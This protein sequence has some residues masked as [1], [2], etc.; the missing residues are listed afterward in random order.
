MKGVVKR[1][2]PTQVVWLYVVVASVLGGAIAAYFFVYV[3]GKRQYFRGEAGRHADAIAEHVREAVDTTATQ[4]GH[5]EGEIRDDSRKGVPF[6]PAEIGSKINLIPGLEHHPP[7]R[8][9]DGASE[10]AC[11][12]PNR[13]VLVQ[14]DWSYSR[15]RV[16]YTLCSEGGTTHPAEECP[17]GAFCA[18][19]SLQAL[20]G[21]LDP[22]NVF[23]DVALG[24]REGSRLLFQLREKPFRLYSPPRI[25]QDTGDAA[26]AEAVGH[27]TGDQASPTALRPA[28]V[29]IAGEGYEL[30]VGYVSLPY[31]GL[32][33]HSKKLI[34]TPTWAVYGWISSARMEA[35]SR[36]LQP[37]FFVALLAAFLFALALPP[38]LK[39]WVLSPGERLRAT[40]IAL[41]GIA[42]LVSAVLGTIAVLATLANQV[43]DSRL[44]QAMHNTAERLDRYV[45]DAEQESSERLSQFFDR[46]PGSEEQ[47]IRVEGGSWTRSTPVF[48]EIF[49]RTD[50]DGKQD[51]KWSIRDARTPKISV[52]TRDYFNHAKPEL[53]RS[54]NTGE[55]LLTAVRRADPD[56]DSKAIEAGTMRPSA[57]LYPVLPIGFGFAILDRDLDV[58]FHSGGGDREVLFDETSKSAE[59]RILHRRRA[60]AA[61]NLDY[62]GSGHSMALRPLGEGSDV[63]WSRDLTLVAFREKIWSR[64]LVFE[65]V[66]LSLIGYA[67]YL[68]LLVLAGGAL[69]SRSQSTLS[70]KIWP[71][72][73]FEALYGRAGLV[74]LLMALVLGLGAFWASAG[75]A[76]AVLALC[77]ILAFGVPS[78]LVR[79]ED[80]RGDAKPGHAGVALLLA[81]LLMMLGAVPAA[82][83]FREALDH[84]YAALVGAADAHWTAGELRRREKLDAKYS[85]VIEFSEAADSDGPCRDAPGLYPAEFL[86]AG[87]HVPG[88]DGGLNVTSAVEW[89]LPLIAAV[90][91]E[92]ARRNAWEPSGDSVS[93]MTRVELV[94]G[95]GELVF[96]VGGLVF[97]ILLGLL[98]LFG[99]CWVTLR[100]LFPAE[101]AVRVPSHRP[102][103]WPASGGN[104]VLLQPR[105]E[106]PGSARTNWLLVAAPEDSVEGW[107][108][109]WAEGE[110]LRLDAAST[111]WP[112]DAELSVASVLL[113]ENF[114]LG[115]AQACS[116]LEKIL[117]VEV[118]PDLNQLVVLSRSEPRDPGAG[119]ISPRWA[120]LLACFEILRFDDGSRAGP[121]AVEEELIRFLP[122]YRKLWEWCGPREKLTLANLANEGFVNPNDV[123]VLHNLRRRGAVL[124]NVPPHVMNESFRRFVI[125]SADR[126]EIAGWEREL[127]SRR[128]AWVRGVVIMIL[129]VA[130]L[131]L[132]A[133]QPVEAKGVLSTIAAAGPATMALRNVIALAQA[134]RGRSLA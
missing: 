36:Q 123:A 18:T 60:T 3:A 129:L 94:A 71:R 105:A 92:A 131:F 10:H 86:G 95:A 57:L 42:A 128:M 97:A 38:L 124:P 67:G 96:R 43:V 54:K 101:L 70:D 16:R 23:E 80:A 100:R 119:D 125:Q 1:T 25:E 26:A 132:I 37:A 81:G 48:P 55:V 75:V 11:G 4:L 19:A 29:T 40:D 61:I 22:G 45:M 49:F 47:P 116:K 84:R 82:I 120:G 89:A 62:H 108:A 51:R 74:L 130:A 127:G 39:L 20:L 17:R 12:G 64:L 98:V 93:D 13:P 79:A 99:V 78:L 133:T 110:R 134:S 63:E 122:R 66:T 35:R 76:L 83:L 69:H 7:F 41:G 117:D 44:D 111:D 77:P 46:A 8:A 73:G 113:V 87:C 27:V 5:L 59:L 65:T 90:H 104:V 106:N 91:P 33:T 85:E 112:S 21:Q 14:L 24:T 109:A 115:S 72:P 32:G 52:A 58:L 103:R 9:L 114:D 6:E 2:R 50:G 31:R 56:T 28:P 118:T 102:A 53:I 126:R 30:Y 121:D 15:P 34:G 107:F 68:V 88:V